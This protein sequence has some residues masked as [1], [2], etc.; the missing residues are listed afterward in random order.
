MPLLM[1]ENYLTANQKGVSVADIDRMALSAEFISFGDKINQRLRGYQEWSLMPNLG[2][3]G[4]LAP[5]QLSCGY[6]PFTKFSEWLGKMSSAKKAGRYIRELKDMMGVTASRKTVHLEYVPLV[7]NVI[8]TCLGQEGVAIPAA[9]D[10]MREYGL[11]MEGL[12]ENV[13]G[14]ILNEDM[15]KEFNDLSPKVKSAFTKAYNEA[16]KQSV[17]AG[18]K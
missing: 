12:K 8:C 10:F 11:S 1:Q 14:L 2:M 9:V 15:V 18:K 5:A 6:L 16:M 3:A 13:L 17:K 7:F 4:C